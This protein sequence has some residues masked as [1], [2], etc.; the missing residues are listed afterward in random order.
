MPERE[1]GR[2]R[3]CS[4]RHRNTERRLRF[5]ER[6]DIRGSPYTGLLKLVA[7]GGTAMS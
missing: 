7:E 2:A 3:D 5:G 4:F 6:P 1:G